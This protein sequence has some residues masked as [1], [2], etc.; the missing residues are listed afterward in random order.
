MEVGGE[1]F[2]RTDGLAGLLSEGFQPVQDGVEGEG[3]QVERGKGGCQMLFAVSEFVGQVV[4]V[5]LQHV[6][7]FVFDL[8]TNAGTGGELGHVVGRNPQAGHE[9]VAIGGLSG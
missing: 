4:A 6:E 3:Q 7:A 9:G 2:A 1:G 5:I 8:P